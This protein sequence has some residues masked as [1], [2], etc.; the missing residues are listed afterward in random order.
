MRAY[1]LFR[2]GAGEDV[3]EVSPGE[4]IGRSDMATLCVDDP[5]VS[6][7]HAMVSLRGQS[8]KLLALRGRFVVD[9]KVSSEATLKKGLEVE[10]ARGLKL[11]CVGVSMP[12]SLPGIEIEGM[13]PFLLT[14]TM[15]FFLENPIRVSNSF[16]P[17]GDMIFWAV[18]NRWRASVGREPAREV[19]IGD[20]IEHEGVTLKITAHPIQNAAQTATKLSLRVP[21]TLYDLGNA[22]RI[23]RDGEPTLLVSGIPGKIF[24][25][26]LKDEQTKDWRDIAAFVWPGDASLQSALRRRFD[27]GLS[28]LRE[29]VSSLTT[30]GEELVRLDGAGMLTLALGEHDRIE[31][32]E[33]GQL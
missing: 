6:E 33:D 13:P 14:G 23:E 8:L 10:L 11:H 20:L 17:R 4:F 27:A 1:A 18:G 12:K 21:M 24:A 29:K 7:A 15:T 5:R 3:I 28:R 32:R 22:V 19:S 31:E 30:D 25:A 16:D 26:L 2:L 9:G